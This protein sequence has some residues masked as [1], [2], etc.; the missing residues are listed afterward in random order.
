M[1]FPNVKVQPH[2]LA[3]LKRAKDALPYCRFVCTAIY[4]DVEPEIEKEIR[5]AIREA[6][7][8]WAIVNTWHFYETGVRLRNSNDYRIAW[9]DH[10]I[11]QCRT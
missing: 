8:P 1:K 4:V 7:H 9:I 3:T 2:W 6:I 10:M 11:A 5:D